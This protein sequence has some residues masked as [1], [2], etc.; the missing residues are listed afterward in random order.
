MQA[1]LV[2]TSFDVHSVGTWGSIRGTG[3]TGGTSQN[4]NPPKATAV[5]NVNAVNRSSRR[6][7]ATAMGFIAPSM[8]AC[9]GRLHPRRASLCADGGLNLQPVV[10]GV[11]HDLAQGGR[12]GRM[13]L[14]EAEVAHH[15]AR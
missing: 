13:L 8:M 7:A 1:T 2:P 3:G 12:Q 9:A 15:L 10:V 14:Q 11:R 5:S 6:R 4:I